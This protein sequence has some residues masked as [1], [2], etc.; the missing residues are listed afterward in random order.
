MIRQD[1]DY[2]S[3]GLLEMNYYT[4]RDG[5]EFNHELVMVKGARDIASAIAYVGSLVE[6]A[7]IGA[8]I[9]ITDNQLIV[10]FNGNGGRGSHNACL[11]RIY[12]DMTDQAKLRY[13]DVVKYRSALEGSFLHGK[14]YVEKDSPSSP[15]SKLLVFSFDR[16][17]RKITPREYEAFRLFYD[18]YG[19]VLKKENFY[20]SLMGRKMS[21]DEVKD[22]LETMIDPNLDISNILPVKERIIGHKIETESDKKTMC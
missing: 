9:V 1:E 17:G 21:I 4:K 3:M 8:C 12:A 13:N 15:V 14:L 5:E 22:T 19:E 16:E 2:H 20:V 6:E 7:E 11:A 10:A 18:E